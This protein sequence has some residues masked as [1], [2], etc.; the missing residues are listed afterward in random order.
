MKDII[1]SH[2][3][4]NNPLSKLI[5]TEVRKCVFYSTT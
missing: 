5:S 1:K 2:I 3:I 4:R